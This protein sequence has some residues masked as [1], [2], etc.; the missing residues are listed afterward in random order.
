MYGAAPARTETCW[1]WSDPELVRKSDKVMESG[2][3][4]E[5]PVVT[6]ENTWSAKPRPK[7]C[8]MILKQRLPDIRS[9]NLYESL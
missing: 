3:W 1:M 5:E 6:I 7:F 8:R 2:I 9:L 4:A